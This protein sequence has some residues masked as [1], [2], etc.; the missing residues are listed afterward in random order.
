MAEFTKK[1][2]QE[3]FDE[4]VNENIEEFEL[5]KSSKIKLI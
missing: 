5:S 1:I 4:V 3:T 2:T